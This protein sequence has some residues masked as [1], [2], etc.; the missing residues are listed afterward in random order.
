MISDIATSTSTG[1]TL[2]LSD[3]LEAELSAQVESAYR[4]HVDE[5]KNKW[6]W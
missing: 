5:A 3:E 1:D 2:E 4:K 6:N